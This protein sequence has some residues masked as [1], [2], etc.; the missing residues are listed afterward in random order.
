MAWEEEVSTGSRGDKKK[1]THARWLTA[2]ISKV[3]VMLFNDLLSVDDWTIQA[4]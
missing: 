3:L 4:R 2:S 1:K